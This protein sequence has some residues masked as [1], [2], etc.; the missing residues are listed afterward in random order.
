MNPAVNLRA[1]YLNNFNK[2]KTSPADFYSNA[3]NGDMSNKRFKEGEHPLF[4]DTK[5]DPSSFMQL[6]SHNN[7]INNNSP[8]NNNNIN[9]FNNNNSP[10]YPYA[11]MPTGMMGY[12]N[13]NDL[14][15]MPSPIGMG[16]QNQL[17]NNSPLNNN[18]NNNLSVGSLNINS[19]S[20]DGKKKRGRPRIHPLPDPKAQIEK[21]I[22]AEKKKLVPLDKAI[23]NILKQLIKLDVNAIFYHPVKDSI[24]PGYSKII[25][26]PMC[27]SKI[28]ERLNAKRYPT[29]AHAKRDFILI[30]ENCKQYNQDD[31][32]YFAEAVRLL[33]ET[34][35]L[36]VQ[37]KEKLADE[38][39]GD[40]ENLP[41]AN[42]YTTPKQKTPK[43]QQPSSPKKTSS[44][45][46]LPTTP[47]SSSS[48]PRLSKTNLSSPDSALPSPSVSTPTTPNTNF[49]QNRTPNS[50]PRSL[51]SLLFFLF[52]SKFAHLLIIVYLQIRGKLVL[53]NL[54]M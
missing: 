42:E 39:I 28:K 31:T 37:F 1:E 53:I 29:L 22:K 34:E 51:N 50:D 40:L 54:V 48:N 2:R 49:L 35:K 14:Q 13:H 47:L 23:S 26:Y 38:E 20:S 52:R 32:I 4:G 46:I 33:E 21:K 9:M 19:P 5:I 15:N 24:A 36:V 25:K 3:S 43:G 27:F 8:L 41:P 44:A 17:N 11:N 18:S 7:N 16:S 6:I 45:S 10:H 12:K 30:F